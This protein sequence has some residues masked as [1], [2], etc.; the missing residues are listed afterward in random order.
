MGVGTADNSKRSLT[1][2]SSLKSC[3]ILS[4]SMNFIASYDPFH[5]GGSLAIQRRFP[6]M[7]LSQLIPRVR[8]L[9]HAS[10]R[11]TSGTTTTHASPCPNSVH[12]PR[13]PYTTLYLSPSQARSEIK[14]NTSIIFTQTLVE[15]AHILPPPEKHLHGPLHRRT[16]FDCT[17]PY[18][19][20]QQV[21]RYRRIE[22]FTEQET[23]QRETPSI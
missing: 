11:L 20:S 3:T 2:T 19:S 18:I 4:C 23:P 10:C 21:V 12:K 22:N 13:T 8:S 7:S 17:S 1:I 15:N 5:T 6:G 9:G 16:R 14:G